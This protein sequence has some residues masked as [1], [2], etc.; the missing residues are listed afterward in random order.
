M[1]RRGLTLLELLI[2]ITVL[3]SIVSG[4]GVF[5]SQ[6]RA[7]EA[8]NARHREVLRVERVLRTLREQWGTRRVLDDE[9]VEEGDAAARGYTF[10]PTGVE[11]TS[12]TGLLAP[13]WALVRVRYGIERGVDGRYAL[14]YE[15]ARVLDMDGSAPA[16]TSRLDARGRAIGGRE[17]VLAGLDGLWFERW[18][19][20]DGEPAPGAIDVR[21][22]DADERE[23]DGEREVM[24][25]RAFDRVIDFPIDAV[26]LVGEVNG[27]VFSCVLVGAPLR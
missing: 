15:E 26:R 11:F 25:W 7:W 23:P 22:D 5:W 21:T 9:G 17:V 10:S 1:K 12:A 2:A 14:V 20:R 3:A 16:G 24:R 8:D 19:T 6:A 18:G 4:V 27:E 13:G